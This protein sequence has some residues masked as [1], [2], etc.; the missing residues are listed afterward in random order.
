[1]VLYH[2]VNNFRTFPLVFSMMQAAS[3]SDF[4]EVCKG[5]ELARNF[6]F[7]VLREVL[8]KV[9][10]FASFKKKIKSL[11]FNLK[12]TGFLFAASAILPSDH[13]R[14]YTRS[15]SDSIGSYRNFGIML[16]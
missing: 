15:P 5:L 10:F 8:G 14:V 13:G 1:M 11:R 7:P 12:Y 2:G 9:R 16:I 3:L 6:Q 4:Y